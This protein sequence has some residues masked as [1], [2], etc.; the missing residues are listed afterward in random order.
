[1]MRKAARNIAAAICLLV[2]IAG[3]FLPFIQGIAMIVLAVVIADFEAKERLLE[4][5]RHTR[6]GRHL[7]ERHEAR[8]ARDAAKC[9]IVPELDPEPDSETLP[10]PTLDAGPAEK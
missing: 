6:I 7:W 5:Y 2:G 10:Q 3:L 4:R 1:M 8:K 9:K